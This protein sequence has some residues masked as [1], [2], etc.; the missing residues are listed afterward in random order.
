MQEF[1]ADLNSTYH[2]L[3]F[4]NDKKLVLFCASGL[5]SVLLARTLQDMG[6]DHVLDMEDGFTKWKMQDLPVDYLT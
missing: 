5:R 2:K 3:V 4:R 6:M 1:W